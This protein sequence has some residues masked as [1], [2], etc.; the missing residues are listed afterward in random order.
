MILPLSTASSFGS[1][2]EFRTVWIVISTSACQGIILLDVACSQYIWRLMLPPYF[3]FLNI[4][5]RKVFK[6]M[7]FQHMLAYLSWCHLC[8]AFGILFML[9][10]PA[11][12]HFSQIQHR[13]EL[14]C[15]SE[16]CDDFTWFWFSCLLCWGI[17]LHQS[18][19]YSFYVIMSWK[20][21]DWMLSAMLIVIDGM[22]G[23]MYHIIHT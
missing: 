11:P 9:V 16:N 13:S 20:W 1:P 23:W 3:L 6:F 18:G 4:T 22:F 15:V 14:I 5:T 21:H 8:D 10:E 2:I 12:Y 17:R 19:T 7:V